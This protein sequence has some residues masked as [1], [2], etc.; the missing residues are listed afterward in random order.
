MTTAD[1]AWP[2]ATVVVAARNAQAS[3]AACLS[4]L[5]A[6]DYP[7]YDVVVVDDG[8]SDDT[9]RLARAAG[10]TVLAGDGRGAGIARNRGI[11]AARGDVVAFT[12]ADCT[13]SPPWLRRLVVGLRQPGVAGCGSRQQ[14]VFPHDPG[15]AVQAF[16]AFFR[17][18]S[19]VSAYTRTDE[20]ARR[21]DHVA[22][23]NSAYWKRALVEVGGFAD[24][25]PGEDVDLDYRLRQKGYGC[26]YVPDAP[27]RHHRPGTTSWFRGMMRRYGRAE[28]ELVRRHGRFRLIHRVPLFV[29]VGLL[30]QL[31]WA[32]PAARPLV[33]AVDAVAILAGL[34]LLARAARPRLWPIVCFYAAVALWEWHRGWL[35]PAGARS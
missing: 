32:V 17:V 13:V 21:V 20:A 14:N 26:Y 30:L 35:E 5:A 23:C 31:L 12:D 19:V 25:W 22:S 34:A 16:D 4:S 6:L 27:V 24:M 9:V 11:D 15:Q 33:A 10:V 2:H 8:S 1:P 7:S 18:A 3:I 28:R 29:A